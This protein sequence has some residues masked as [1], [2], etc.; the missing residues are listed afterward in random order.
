MSE[1]TPTS[2]GLSS[3]ISLVRR[4]R[5]YR[6]LWLGQIVSLLG[7]WFNLIASAALIGALTQ[8]GL[9]IGG[10]FVVRMLAP[11]LVSPVAGVFA[12]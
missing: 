2:T 6:Y 10:L 8:S 1:K 3:Y 11:F 12:D 7:D 4:N 9:A 5:N